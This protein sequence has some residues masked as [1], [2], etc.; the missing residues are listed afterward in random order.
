MQVSAEI[1]WFWPDDPPPGLYDWFVNGSG[2]I[3]AAGG[4]RPDRRDEYLKDKKQV[5]LGIKRR[6]G[7]G[8]GIEVKGLVAARLGGVEV[9]PFIGTIELWTKWSSKLLQLEPSAT[10]TVVKQR[11]L[12]KF[13]TVGSSPREIALTSD[14]SPKDEQSLPT[15]GCNV[16][17]TRVEVLGQEGRWWTLGFEAFGDSTSVGG[18]LYSVAA[19]LSRRQPPRLEG[20]FLASYPAW[21]SAKILPEL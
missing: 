13:S 20:G 9:D 10:I 16:E 4:G 3:C 2:D 8:S 6:G 19:F 11:W 18:D 12:R 15:R 1:R 21:L 14:E 7:S 5:E 17:L